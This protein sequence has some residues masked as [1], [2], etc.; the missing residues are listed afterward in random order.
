M[1]A[2]QTLAA[3]A[4]AT[5]PHFR[6]AR[7]LRL[8]EVAT[9]VGL[10]KTAIYDLIKRNSFPRPIKLGAASVWVDAEI[11]EWIATLVAQRDSTQQN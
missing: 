1:S 4:A 5:P 8:P 2:M 10:A 7:L 9:R 6:E 11:S 3:F